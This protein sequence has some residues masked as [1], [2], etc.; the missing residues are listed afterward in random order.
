MVNESK[1]NTSV[2]E[3]PGIAAATLY[4]YRKAFV[5][6][7]IFRL[8][9]LIHNLTPSKNRLFRILPFL[10]HVNAPGFPGYVKH[11]KTPH[12]IYR[13]HQSGFWDFAMK[14]FKVAEKNGRT[15]FPKDPCIHGLYLMGS[16]GT[17]AQ[18]AY[19][20]FDY[21]LL[22]D[23]SE[24]DEESLSLLT[25]KISKIERWCQDEYGQPVTFF[26]I[27]LEAVK[28]NNF[29]AVDQESSGS[30]QRTF[31]K[32]EFYRTFIMVAGQIPYWAILP[33]KMSDEI[34]SKWLQTISGAQTVTFDPE[35]YIDLG[36]LCRVDDK[37]CLGA[38]LWQIYK[39]GSDP[40]K[41]LIKATHIAY[42]NHF[43]HEEGL[44][45]EKIKFMYLGESQPLHLIDPYSIIF[46]K[47]LAFFNIL[48]DESGIDLV[49]KAIFLKLSAKHQDPDPDEDISHRQA[50]I[51]KY[52]REWDWDQKQVDR[53]LQ[54]TQWPEHKRVAFESQIFSKISFLYGLT[55][56]SQ[57]G[58]MAAFDMSDDD[59][60][61][62]INR[63]QS[64]RKV[65]PGKIPLCSAYLRSKT[66]K[67]GLILSCHLDELKTPVWA[68]YDKKKGINPVDKNTIVF[69]GPELLHIIGWSV[70]NKLFDENTFPDVM[71]NQCSGSS[72]NYERIFRESYQFLDVMDSNPGWIIDSPFWT[73][74]VMLLKFKSDDNGINELVSMNLLLK[75]SWDE[76]F[77]ELVDLAD[78]ENREIKCYNISKIIW[79]FKQHT[80]S[81]EL[82]YRIFYIGS[83][84]DDN[85]VSKISSFLDGL[86]SSMTDTLVDSIETKL[87]AE[88]EP[89]DEDRPILDI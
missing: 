14:H 75:N 32:E 28:E 59:L 76:I 27:D 60:K 88:P 50:I 66:S 45:C 49:R 1:H 21:W 78:I 72:R 86:E 24:L 47:A 17:I 74:L 54:Y 40:E 64:Q 69:S 10:L 3:D 8:K 51:E 15:I 71:L 39:A 5:S 48:G 4:R 58:E 41:S 23:K 82:P 37:E 43:Q 55:L 79:R 33:E 22:I 19:S 68:V 85:C 42:C 84:H 56:K 16:A 73:G 61:A 77:F 70:I 20:D 11:L 83:N 25:I 29:A 2:P 36:N 44:L 18:A 62:L 26:I 35:D 57:K 30:A 13:F 87:D 67:P 63:I 9:K 65:K 53:Y 12:G 81:G 80:P 7:N 89:G 52:M 34:Y 31:L 38:M 6:Y 46:E